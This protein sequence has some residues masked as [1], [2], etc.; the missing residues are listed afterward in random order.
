MVLENGTVVIHEKLYLASYLP[1]IVSEVDQLFFDVSKFKKLNIS[2]PTC[3]VILKF[4]K[5]R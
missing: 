2:L 3:M 5:D 4:N 1:I